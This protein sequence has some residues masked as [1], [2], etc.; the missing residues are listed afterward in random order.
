MS[1]CSALCR[2]ATLKTFRRARLVPDHTHRL[3]WQSSNYSFSI[4]WDR[5][6]RTQRFYSYTHSTPIT[7][8]IIQLLLIHLVSIWTDA[9]FLLLLTQHSTTST[10]RK[11]YYK[12]RSQYR[13]QSHG[14]QRRPRDRVPSASAAG[15]TSW[16]RLGIW[17][18]VTLGMVPTVSYRS[19]I[20]RQQ[21]F[22][23]S[24]LGNQ[25]GASLGLPVVNLRK[26]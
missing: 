6:R 22:F 9:T 16:I 1:T 5:G 12:I 13:Q 17:S 18:T 8:A 19:P 3:L 10:T 21:S 7:L 14:L 20:V 23:I 25:G 26:I 4:H 11:L 2:R 15:G 24:V